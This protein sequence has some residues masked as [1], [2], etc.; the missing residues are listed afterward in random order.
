MSVHPYILSWFRANQCLLLFLN[1]VYL[2]EFKV[3][4]LTLGEEHDAKKE[5]Y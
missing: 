1:V 5:L 4:G 3:I 2:V